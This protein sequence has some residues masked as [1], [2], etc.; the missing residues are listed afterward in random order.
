MEE[1]TKIR[2]YLRPQMGCD[3]ELFIR[4]DGKLVESSKLIKE[5]IEVESRGKVVK[6][7][8]QIEL[9]PLNNHCRETLRNNIAYCLKT[10]KDVAGEKGFELDW[11]PV[12]ELTEEE[13]DE[14]SAEGKRFGCKPSYNVYLPKGNRESEITVDPKEYRFRSAGGHLHLGIKGY[15]NKE[16]EK[17]VL[18]KNFDETIKLLDYIVGNTC[19]MFE[20]DEPLIKERRRVYGKAGEYRTPKYGIEYRTL[21][22]FWM[23]DYKLMSMVFGLARI[24]LSIAARDDAKN[25]AI[26]TILSSVGESR[27]IKAINEND[28]ELAKRNF[29]RIC[30]AL[31]EVSE[32]GDFTITKKKEELYIRIAEKGINSYYKG[33]PEKKWEGYLKKTDG[34]WE[35]F[36]TNIMRKEEEK[37]EAR[38]LLE[39][40][41]KEEKKQ[42]R[43][44]K[45]EEMVI[46][47][48]V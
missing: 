17:K 38:M 33:R 3:P 31:R 18:E 14:V 10:L 9:N 23:K 32:M 36:L 45:K 37:R 6:D 5:D 15:W 44:E 42:S 40:I 39:E 2:D 43:K 27:V 48:A 16:D 4:K 28:G 12:V 26:G 29:R 7:G 25:K 21:S 47:N 1:K 11:S 13:M 30:K 19:V 20:A 41:E 34:G 8:I 35:S 46:E 24:A 22:N